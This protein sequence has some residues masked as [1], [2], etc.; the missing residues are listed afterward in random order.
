[1]LSRY[2]I[3]RPFKGVITGTKKY[4]KSWAFLV[5]YQVTLVQ[6]L[7]YNVIQIRH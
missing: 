4:Q 3:V 7:N 6:T 5:W 2:I 1:M